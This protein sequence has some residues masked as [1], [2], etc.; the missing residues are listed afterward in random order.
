MPSTSRA[1]AA[2]KPKSKA[3]ASQPSPSPSRNGSDVLADLVLPAAPRWRSRAAERATRALRARADER[4]DRFLEAALALLSEVGSDFSVREVVELSKMSRRLFYESFGGKDDL[5]LAIYEE[6]TTTGLDRQL[7]AVDAAGD[8]PLKRLRAFMAAEWVVAEKASPK[9][10]RALATYH[11]RLAETRPAEL[12]AI[13]QPQHQ[14]LTQLLAACRE[15]GIAGPHL[16]DSTNASILMHLMMTT[17]QAR[18]LD[19]RVGGE[20]IDENQVWTF[21]ESTFGSGDS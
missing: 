18:V 9:L 3:V 2:A 10:Q 16:K 17:L 5:F 20:E 19:Y 14:A 7:E 12:A 15:V 8:D 4:N 6:A 13:L 21:L 11:L 1:K